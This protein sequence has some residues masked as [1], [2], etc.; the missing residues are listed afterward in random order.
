MAYTCPS[1]NATTN[2]TAFTI[3]EADAE[4][5]FVAGVSG[6]SFPGA[7]GELERCVTRVAGCPCPVCDEAVPVKVYAAAR[8]G[9]DDSDEFD[10]ITEF[11]E[12]CVVGPGH[13]T[14]GP[15]AL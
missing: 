10:E 5:T 8:F 11:Y 6:I 9:V 3:D 15:T 13:R 14:H 7:G 2:H 4:D 1:C 12:C